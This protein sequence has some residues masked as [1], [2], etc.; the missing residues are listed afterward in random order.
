MDG[1]ARMSLPY[2]LSTHSVFSRP[3]EDTKEPRRIV[4]LS[5]EG[6]KTEVQYFH[7]VELY[8]CR[9]NID[10]IVHVEVLRK[11]DTKSDLESVYRLLEDYVSFRTNGQFENELQKLELRS[12]A[13]PFIQKYLQGDPS[14]SLREK[15]RFEAVLREEHLDLQYLN[16]LNRYKGESDIFGVVIDRDCKNHTLTQMEEMIQK[17]KNKSYA[18]F[19][20]NPCFEFWQLLH[21]SDVAAEYSEQLDAIL[22]NSLDAQGNTFVSNLLFEKTGQRKAIQDKTFLRYYLPN[23]DLAIDRAKAFA[24]SDELIDKLGTNVGELFAL[25]R[26]A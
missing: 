11:T 2:R 12:F 6:T 26:D 10:A 22:E 7:F 14:I 24:P 23:I 1:G 9:L 20:S 19:I 18:Y 8:R 13:V 3:N 16:F 4:F 15:R 17:C 5:V 21:V 25:L